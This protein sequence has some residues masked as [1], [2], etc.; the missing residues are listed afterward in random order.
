MSDDLLKQILDELESIKNRLTNLEETQEEQ[1]MILDSLSS[2]SLLVEAKIAKID[3]RSINKDLAR[4]EGIL[5]TLSS[6]SIT[7]E[8]DIAD[9]K[10]IK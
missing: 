2:R 3:T 1:Q 6:R 4:H 7:Q 8:A 10:R 5:T 9:I